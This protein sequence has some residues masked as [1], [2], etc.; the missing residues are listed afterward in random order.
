MMEIKQP[1]LPPPPLPFPTQAPTPPLRMKTTIF[2]PFL[3]SIS[4]GRVQS[5]PVYK[6][7]LGKERVTTQNRGHSVQE[8]CS[9]A[10]QVRFSELVHRASMTACPRDGARETL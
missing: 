5:S 4:Q 9:G 6:M 2:K 1:F 7:I 8:Q 10:P 3:I